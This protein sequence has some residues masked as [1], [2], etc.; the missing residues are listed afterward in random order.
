[1]LGHKALTETTTEIKTE[2]KS[3][4]PNYVGTPGKQF[5]GEKN[6]GKKEEKKE[7]KSSELFPTQKESTM[8]PSG[9]IQ[10]KTAAEIWAKLEEKK[11][12]PVQV[13]PAMDMPAKELAHLWAQLLIQHGEAKFVPVPTLKELGQFGQYRKKCLANK[14]PPAVVMASIV[15]HWHTF[16]IRVRES[17][18]T[19]QC[20]VSPLL[21]YLLT[22][23]GIAVDLWV[24][25]QSPA[26]MITPVQQ[27]PKAPVKTVVKEP[28]PEE[29]FAEG[30]TPKEWYEK[31]VA[32]TKKG[33]SYEKKTP[34]FGSKK[35]D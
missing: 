26:N 30:L 9:P 20:P 14:I 17:L 10:H 15:K 35:E 2:T 13:S 19:N 22:H 32:P 23:F 7:E 12:E 18:G 24:C 1:V 34:V 27:Q 11:G 3:S 25:S 6:P 5:S 29:P 16:T 28:E 8:K 31:Y 4:G 33:K 21:G